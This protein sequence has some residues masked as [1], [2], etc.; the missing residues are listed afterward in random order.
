M[1]GWCQH[2]MTLLAALPVWNTHETDQ[3][4][5]VHWNK[6]REVG[7]WL[8]TLLERVGCFLNQRKIHFSNLIFFLW[9]LAIK[10]VIIG[11]YR[12][13]EWLKTK[14]CKKN[15]EFNR[16]L[17]EKAQKLFVINYIKVF[18]QS[19]FTARLFFFFFFFFIWL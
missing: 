5:C 10:C 11:E 12:E 4:D 1:Y 2:R 14:F 15:G 3:L 8:A 9:L 19:V 17:V 6:Y 13:S 7:F 18:K 16:I